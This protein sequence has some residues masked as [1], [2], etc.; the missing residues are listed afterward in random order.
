MYLTHQYAH[1]HSS[2][3]NLMPY[4]LKGVDCII[5]SVFKS[6]GLKAIARPVMGKDSDEEEESG[7]DEDFDPMTDHFDDPITLIGTK[8]HEMGTGNERADD[9]SRNE[10]REVCASSFC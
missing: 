7:D 4:A 8:F 6:L 9:L 3:A 5:F 2:A 10:L 1:T